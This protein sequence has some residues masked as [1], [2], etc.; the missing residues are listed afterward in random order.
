L[1]A[2]PSRTNSPSRN[3]NEN[4]YLKRKEKMSKILNAIGDVKEKKEKEIT[5]K[6]NEYRM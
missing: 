2:S 6:H 1:N 5:K 4:G 3:N